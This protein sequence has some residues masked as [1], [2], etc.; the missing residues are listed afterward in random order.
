MSRRFIKLFLFGVACGIGAVGAAEGAANSGE[1]GFER[2]RLS[3]QFRDVAL[4]DGLAQVGA[5]AQVEFTVA[6]NVDGELNAEFADQPLESAIRRLLK[7]YNFM[8][9]HGPPSIAGAG[10]GAGAAERRPQK[11]NV[12]ARREFSLSSLNAGLTDL[13]PTAA[14]NPAQAVEVVLKRSAKGP[15]AGA[16]LINGKPVEFLIDTGATTVALS[17]DL[18]NSL[19]LPYGAA[20]SIDTANGPATGFET[21]LHTLKLGRLRL[22]RV[23]AI[24][25]PGMTMGRRVLLGMNVLGALEIEQR[26]GALILR[27]VPD[28]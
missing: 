1:V 9:V 20:K 4:R 3:V 5:A 27:Q 7:D 25:I 12:L 24:I 16:G 28:R 23:P 17:G 19:G 13:T 21:L 10:E 15:Y 8:I 14:A 11:V 26:D 18:A 2:G 22:A 6:A